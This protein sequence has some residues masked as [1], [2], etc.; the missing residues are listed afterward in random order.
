LIIFSDLRC[1]QYISAELFE[2]SVPVGLNFHSSGLACSF[3]PISLTKVDPSDHT[4]ESNAIHSSIESQQ[5]A[6]SRCSA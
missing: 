2:P 6:S 4:L 3:S 1:M 5:P